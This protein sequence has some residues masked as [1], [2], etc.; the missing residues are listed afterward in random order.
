MGGGWDGGRTSS[1]ALPLAIDVVNKYPSLEGYRIGYVWRDSR[2]NA[3]KALAAMSELLDIGV[4]AFIG[5]GCSTACRRADTA[6][7]FES[8]SSSGKVVVAGV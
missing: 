1:A 8:K 5:P 6:F 4:D 2:C 3:G 7:G